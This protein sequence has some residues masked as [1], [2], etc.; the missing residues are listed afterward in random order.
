MTEIDAV[1]RLCHR[2]PGRRDWASF[3][4]PEVAER[5]TVRTIFRVDL[6]RRRDWIELHFIGE[7]FLRYQVRRM[8]GA[9][10]AVGHGRLAPE[11]FAD[12]VARPTPGAPVPTA[13]ACGLS[14]ERVFYR[15]S[16]K[17]ATSGGGDD[18]LW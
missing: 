13:P 15:A 3:S 2:L 9:L 4:V 18:P 10:A 1:C 6:R 16:P 17:L 8:V 7:G 12:L 14:L 11:S 5:A